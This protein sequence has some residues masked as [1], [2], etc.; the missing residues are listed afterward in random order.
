M[1]SVTWDYSK[2]QITIT[3]DAKK[4]DP[5]AFA[6]TITDLGYTVEEVA[7]PKLKA[8]TSFARVK[9]VLPKKAPKDFMRAFKAAREAKRPIVIDFWA[10]WCGPCIK[11]KK[12]TLR[13][14]E[15]EKALEGVELIYV[16]LDEN[17]LLA[18]TFE[19]SS[20]PDVLFIDSEGFI[21][22]RLKGFEEAPAFLERL[23]QLVPRKHRR[24]K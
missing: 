9:A 18:K 20:V 12:K 1:I 7:P 2:D 11:L 22:D 6:K 5:K 4:A 15:V 10:T 13:N 14:A 19:V 17:P 21:V 8:P 3:Y 16:D 24:A 23:K